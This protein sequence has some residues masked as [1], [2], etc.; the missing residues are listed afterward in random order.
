MDLNKLGTTAY[1][2]NVDF[3]NLPAERGQSQPPPTP[4]A[5]RFELTPLADENFDEVASEK[6]G[7]RVKVKFNAS[8]PL[9]IVQ[10]P[11]SAHNGDPFTTTI[12][13]VPRQRG[14][15]ESMISSDWDYLNRAL[16]VPT[17]PVGSRGYAVQLIADSKAVPPKQFSADIEWTWNCSDKRDAFFQQQ[18]GGSAPLP[19]PSTPGKNIQGCGAKYYQGQPDKGKAADVQA[20][21]AGYIEPEPVE[22][23][24]AAYPLYIVCSCGATVRAFGNLSRIRE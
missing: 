17:R 1:A 7:A 16:K 5:Y 4:G 19:D 14:K 2:D 20:N 24:K 15:D 10:S 13:N 11:A 22:G 9:K 12:T 6:H 8:A 23:G 3:D 21:K 18:E